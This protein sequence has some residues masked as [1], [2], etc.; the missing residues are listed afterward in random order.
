MHAMPQAMKDNVQSMNDTEKT[1]YISTG[2]KS[3]YII[4]EW[5]NVYKQML[6]FVNVL[7]DGYV[8]KMK[9]LLAR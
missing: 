5:T 6:C 8:E 1:L 7:Y 2:M 4:E 3:E 9:N